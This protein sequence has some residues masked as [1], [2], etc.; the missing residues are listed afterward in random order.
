MIRQQTGEARSQRVFLTDD[1]GLPLTGLAPS[2]LAWKA[3]DGAALPAPGVQEIGG[4]FYRILTG[5][6]QDDAVVRVDRG[7]PGSGRYVALEVVVGGFVDTL[8]TTI[9]SR[10]SAGQVVSLAAGLDDIAAQL[11]ALADTVT[12][13]G[14]PAQAAELVALA[15]Q[16]AA[17]GSP[18]QANDPRLDLLDV[19][20]STRATPADVT[21]TV[22]TDPEVEVG[23]T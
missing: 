11:L 20:V 19:A 9:T 3:T 1:D 23:G 22:E 17:L 18:V 21:V 15:G 10:A 8:D 5:A 4:G 12:D 2:A 16:V 6:L 13:L 7:T 14:Q